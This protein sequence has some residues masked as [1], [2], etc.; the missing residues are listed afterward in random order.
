[1]NTLR[2]SRTP[3]E[4][5]ATIRRSSRSFAI[6]VVVHALVI[7]ALVRFLISPAAFTLIFGHARSVEIQPDRISFLRLPKSNGPP[8]AGRSGGDNRPLSKTP[9]RP[10]FAPTVVPNAIPPIA[11]P[12]QPEPEGGSGPLV[13]SGGPAQGI[14]PTY[15]DPRVWVAPGEI[16]AAPKTA[17]QKMDS[18]VADI[19]APFND[20]IAAQ[21]GKR[22]PGDWTIDR[23]GRKWGVDPK[24]IHLGKFQIPTAVLALLPMNAQANPSALERNKLQNQL[25]AD[26]FWN[27]QRGMNEAD[28]KKAVKSI[29]E[30]KE[31]EKKEAEKQAHQ[32]DGSGA[33]DSKN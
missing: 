31:R 21:S 18:V 30:R 19:I 13:G 24:Y 26:I 7:A 20:S 28:F 9:A 14:R 29:R 17:Q 10:I 1:M 27:A 12:K 23:N 25:H 22:Q 3:V 33:Q 32:S 2:N 11:A 8:V 4:P 16:V 5:D 15:S 6:S